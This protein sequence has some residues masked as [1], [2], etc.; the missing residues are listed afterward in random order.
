[1]SAQVP[2][3]TY[4]YQKYW[5]GRE[6]EDE[7]EKLTLFKFLQDIAD[8]QK[9][10]EQ[11]SLLDIGGGFGRITKA[12]APF[13]QKCVLLEPSIKLRE[14]AKEYLGKY[15]NIQI[16]GGTAEKLPFDDK[17]F[18]TIILIR[19]FHHLPNPEKALQEAARVLKSGGFLILE[20]ANKNHFRA[21]VRSLLKGNFLSPQDLSSSDISTSIHNRERIPFVNHHP[22]LIEQLLQ[23]TNFK[24]IGGC[25][26]SNFRSPLIKKI[27]PLS[28]LLAFESYCQAKLFRYHFGP[29]IFI[30]AQKQA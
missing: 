9:K 11:R 8:K 28:V 29:S 26:V 7:A 23:K 4:D 20:F 25:S 3:D 21:H 19:V 12:C 22:I 18:D 27:I 24:I 6:Y 30:L 16:K 5:V 1:M 15:S 10:T 2:Y 17:T 14:E 13:F